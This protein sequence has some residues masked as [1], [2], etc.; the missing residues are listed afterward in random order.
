M[1]DAGHEKLDYKGEDQHGDG[2][3]VEVS[4]RRGGYLADRL[5]GELYADGN[6]EH[7]DGHAG[8]VLEATVTVWVA[9]V[10]GAACQL[11]ANEAHDIA[12]GVREVVEGIC[13]DGDRAYHE[14]NNTLGRAQEQVET[15]ANRAGEKSVGTARPRVPRVCRIGHK[16]GDDALCQAC[17]H[18]LAPPSKTDSFATLP[19]CW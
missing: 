2:E 3:R 10:G 8:Q 7:G 14:A 13:S 19:G 4:R 11:E 1:V 5:P 16:A 9:L 15:Y 17:G 12:R 6:D 18:G